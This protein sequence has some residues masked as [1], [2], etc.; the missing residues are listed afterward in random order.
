M[1]LACRV[2][3]R[4]FSG[5]HP[6]WSFETFSRLFVRTGLSLLVAALVVVV[7]HDS[8]AEPERG[9]LCFGRVPTIVGTNGRDVIRGTDG[10]DVI[11]ARG[12]AD[13]VSAGPG[14]DFICGGRGRDDPLAGNRGYDR[15][16]G[17]GGTDY[18]W[19]FVREIVV[20]SCNPRHF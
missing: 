18:C 3:S 12:G 5:W 17:G 13:H 7:P 9:P 16:H 20:I 15:F 11:H 19:Y 10:R 8:E 1:S 14:D 4:T 2:L 6:R